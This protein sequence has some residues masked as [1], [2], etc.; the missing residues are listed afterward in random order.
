MQTCSSGA[1]S[2]HDEVTMPTK[3]LSPFWSFLLKA[4]SVIVMPLLTA[5]VLWI[6]GIEGNAHAAELRVATIEADR[7]H[8]KE[9]LELIRAELSAIHTSIN[10]I[11]TDVAVLA[12]QPK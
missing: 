8:T 11:T 4:T 9:Q 5:L 10:K 3:G 2:A 1:K 12:N 7:A 6:R